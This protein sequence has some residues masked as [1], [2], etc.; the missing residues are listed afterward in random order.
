M[1]RFICKVL[2]GIKV[3]LGYMLV[4]MLGALSMLIAGVVM[5][6]NGLLK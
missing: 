6:L 2:D 5:Y 1:K 4:Y 3:F